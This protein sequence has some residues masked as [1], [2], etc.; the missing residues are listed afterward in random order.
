[1]TPKVQSLGAPVRADTEAFD[2]LKAI[3]TDAFAAPES[4]YRRLSADE[5]ISAAQTPARVNGRLSG[6]RSDPRD[7]PGEDGSDEAGDN[8]SR[9]GDQG[10]FQPPR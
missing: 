6:S 2:R 5:V 8:R 9:G 7:E 3:L 10:G 4:A 1:M